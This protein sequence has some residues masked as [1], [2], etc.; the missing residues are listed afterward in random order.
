MD[1]EVFAR[2]APYFTE[3]FGNASSKVHE[4]GWKAEA[5]VELAREQVARLIGGTPRELVFTSGATESNMLAIFGVA[6]SWLQ[7]A[8]VPHLITTAVEHRAVLEPMRELERRGCALTVLPVDRYGRVDPGDV[9]R[10]IRPD[11]ALVSV[12]F[13]NNEVGTIQPVAEIGA[14]CKAAGVLFHTDA[15]QAGSCLEVDVQA[16]GVDLLTLSAHKMYGPKSVGVLYV[17]RHGPR[18]TLVPR[19]F[20]GGQERGLR[21]GTLNVPGIVGMGAASEL[22]L[23]RRAE[24]RARISGLRD[25]LWSALSSGLEGVTLNGHATERLPGNLNVCF[26][27]VPSE[28]FLMDLRDLAAGSGSA[29]ASGSGLPSH[30]LQALGVPETL[31]RTSIRYGIGRGTTEQEIDYAAA[32]SIEAA[33]NLRLAVAAGGSEEASLRTDGVRR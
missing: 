7:G 31:S 25:R 15:A 12:I 26:E 23:R 19:S 5:A 20:G 28:A 27:G 11:T 17:R 13:A 22:A 2:M 8:R 29:C 32:R 1:S 18:V 30:V 10:A 9:R 24:D 21:P 14:L 16:L 4:F 3:H 6:E 33:R